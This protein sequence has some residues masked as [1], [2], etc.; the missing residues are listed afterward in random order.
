MK[1]K[2]GYFILL[3][4]L[5]IVF[6]SD[7]L[8]RYITFFSQITQLGFSVLFIVLLLYIYN[9]KVKPKLVWMILLSLTILVLGLFRNQ[10]LINL[11]QLILV[12]S[13]FIFVFF[14]DKFD[15]QVC[16]ALMKL[17]IV[18][19]VLQLFFDLSFP[20]DTI[21][22]LDRYSGT[23]IMA[24]NKSRFLFFILPYLFFLNKRK[25]Y[26]GNL[27]KLF[28]IIIIGY[29]AYLGYSYLG[30]LILLISVILAF[31]IKNIYKLTG[32]MIILIYMMYAI[33]LSEYKKREPGKNYTAMQMN[34]ERFF[35]SEIGVAAVYKYGYE[36]LKDTYFIG[37][38][39]GNF[40]SRSGQ[41]FDSEITK[42]I[43]K[44]MIKKWYPLFENKSPYGLSSLFVLFV[45]LGFFSII[46]IFILLRWLHSLIRQGPYYIRLM[47][48]YLFFMIN[49][50]PTFFEFNESI[51][52]LLTLII[53]H[54][55]F[56]FNETKNLYTTT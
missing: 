51:L 38:G 14:E 27:G 45:E 53:A 39:Y 13:N 40:T 46:P 11:F 29:S 50:N 55:L 25:F 4:Q 54:K 49:Y 8:S 48:I 15:E 23:F 6:F 43:P 28:S 1:I 7:F 31:Y 56:A 42:N 19:C 32:A 17:I 16:R 20:R 22:P 47:V 3:L 5:L 24:N 52:Y 21:D 44:Q 18:F 33:S 37:V 30:L 9:R 2:L 26:F 41:I 10:V 35:D 34:Y 12:C 36:Q